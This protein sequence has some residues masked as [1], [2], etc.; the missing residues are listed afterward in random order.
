MVVGEWATL[1]MQS[2][3]MSTNASRL[4]VPYFPTVASRVFSEP[5][6]S[7]AVKIS[8]TT[9][10]Y[11][12]TTSTKQPPMDGLKRKH[13]VFAGG[14]EEPQM[15]AP[16]GAEMDT[17]AI[18]GLHPSRAAVVDWH[19]PAPAKKPKVPKVGNAMVHKELSS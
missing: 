12:T 3:A 11:S 15:D 4:P 8:V 18:A 13:V 2:K 16:A 10:L 6:L 17:P 14:D 19:K 9:S 1:N 5:P 7:V